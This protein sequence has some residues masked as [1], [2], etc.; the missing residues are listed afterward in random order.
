[1][2]C[3]AVPRTG[4]EGSLWKPSARAPSGAAPT[5]PAAWRGTG[6][7]PRPQQALGGGPGGGTGSEGC[8]VEA[9]EGRSRRVQVLAPGSSRGLAAW[10]HRAPSVGRHGR[11][12][13]RFG[14][15]P[16]RPPALPRFVSDRFP[17]TA[18]SF[19]FSCLNRAAAFIT[20]ANIAARASS[21]P[22]VMV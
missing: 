1:M 8:G 14:G 2:I 17:P 9:G 3:K 21:F 20:R 15:L 4:Q 11:A 16:D 6:G 19:L 22:F 10:G 18:Q 7:S 5:A 13:R 12:G